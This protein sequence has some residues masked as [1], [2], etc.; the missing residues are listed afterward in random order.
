MATLDRDGATFVL[1]LGETENRFNADSLGELSALLD[2]A[3][4]VDGP[5]ALVVKATGKYW[6]NGLD[7]DW[8]MAD[9]ERAGPLL[10]GVHALYAR[11]LV[12]PMPTV[13]AITGHAYAGGAMLSV[14]HDIK[15]MRADRGYWCLPEVDLGLPFTPGMNALLVAKLP[16]RTAHESMTT[17]RR[18]T[19]PEAVDA[20]ILDATAA[21]DAVVSTAIERAAA[22]AGKAGPALGE[23][24]AR[25]YADA[26]AALTE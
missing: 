7:L 12:A 8:M 9:T 6:S 23:I 1:D 15:V 13:A 22:L 19:A 3:E 5:K 2:E 20:G 25:L 24:K 11:I 21:E 4:A 14:A 10:A 18:Y 16:K 17:G 26:L